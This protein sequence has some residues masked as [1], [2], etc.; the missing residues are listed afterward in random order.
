MKARKL[1]QSEEHKGC[2][3]DQSTFM[4]AVEKKNKSIKSAVETK[5][6]NYKDDQPDISRRKRN[7]F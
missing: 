5:S 6:K 1:N 2:G 4:E 7:N 3:C